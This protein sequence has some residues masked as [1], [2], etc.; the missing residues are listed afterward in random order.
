M[1]GKIIPFKKPKE[2]KIALFDWA[3]RE[4]S[5]TAE[6]ISLY[7][8]SDRL[9]KDSEKCVISTFPDDKSDLAIMRRDW[10]NL[11]AVTYNLILNY[12]ELKKQAPNSVAH[13]EK[14]GQTLY[15]F[16]MADPAK[17]CR[18]KKRGIPAFCGCKY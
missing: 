16:Y 12:E 11:G 4:F 15:E 13:M 14:N 8:S 5:F 9:V 10:V 18:L 7:F 1:K 2:D 6:P 17:K 3:V